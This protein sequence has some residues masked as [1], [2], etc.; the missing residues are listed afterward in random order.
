M[1]ALNKL[2]ARMPF[3]FAQESKPVLGPVEGLAANGIARS[4]FVLGLSKDLSAFP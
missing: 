2:I 1:E 3:D 4:P